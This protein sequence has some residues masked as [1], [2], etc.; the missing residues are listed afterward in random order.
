MYN[1]N[2]WNYTFILI[3]ASDLIVTKTLL[4]EP[5][6]TVSSLDFLLGRNQSPSTN[7]VLVFSLQNCKWN[8][9]RLN[10]FIIQLMK[11]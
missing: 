9:R 3:S 2:V 4:R 1:L 10:I 11:R 8:V 6:F 7:P 5:S